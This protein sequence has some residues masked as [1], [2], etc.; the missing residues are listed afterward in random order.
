[1][2]KLITP[3]N[4]ELAPKEIWLG[5][6]IMED[7]SDPVLEYDYLEEPKDEFKPVRYIR[8]DLK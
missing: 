6:S 2:R 1:M 8:A 5:F 7:S 4:K 3:E